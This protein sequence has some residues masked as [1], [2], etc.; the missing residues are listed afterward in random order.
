MDPQLFELADQ[1]RRSPDDSKPSYYIAPKEPFDEE[2]R[3]YLLA[4]T[5][6]LLMMYYNHAEDHIA[7]V[8]ASMGILRRDLLHA[9]ADQEDI[10]QLDEVLA[11]KSD[12]IYWGQD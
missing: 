3:G 1:L 7:S 2:R 8:I 10:D 11:S 5:D 12:S 9:G 6:M 4:C